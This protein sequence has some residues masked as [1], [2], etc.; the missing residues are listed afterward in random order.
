MPN[1]P[2][3]EKYKLFKI[4]IYKNKNKFKL[5]IIFFCKPGQAAALILEWLGSAGMTGCHRNKIS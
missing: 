2:V 4:Q 5:K 1:Y 3:R